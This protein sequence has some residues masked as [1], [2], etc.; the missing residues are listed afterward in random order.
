MQ[1]DMEW[2]FVGASTVRRDVGD[3]IIRAISALDPGQ[4]Y[5]DIRGEK[6]PLVSGIPDT[7]SPTQS[8]PTHRFTTLTFAE[9]ISVYGSD[10][11][12]LRIPSR[13][14]FYGPF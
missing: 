3:I 14:S 8:K 13:V 7:P 2:A 1:L 4:T 6:I 11:P 5:K 12:D 9:C 10:K